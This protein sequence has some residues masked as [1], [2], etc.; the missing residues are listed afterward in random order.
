MKYFIGVDG[1]ATQSSAAVAGTNGKIISRKSGPALNYHAIGEKQCEKN[2]RKLLQ[3]LLKKYK[4]VKT[5]VIGFAGLDSPQDRQAYKKIVKKVLPRNIKALLFNDAE[6]ALEAACFDHKKPRILIICGTGSSVYGEYGNK[7][8]KAIGWGFLLGDDG[9][10]FWLGS[11]ALRSAVRVWDGREKK[12]VLE[13]LVL[14]KAGKKDISQLI[15]EIYDYWHEKP[16]EFKK[17][18]ASF[19][20]LFH[21]AKKDSV[22][23]KIIEQAAE[24]L[25]LGARAVAKK[26]GIRNKPFCVG[27]IGS[28]FKNP[29]LLPAL[30]GKIK[31]Q[32]P[33]VHFVYNVNPL[34]G[35]VNL[36]IK[37]AKS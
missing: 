27:F 36:A 35:A 15:P 1:G 16:E 37:H 31:K 30:V 7:K 3:P 12:T 20:T 33:K 18:I 14:R 29:G 5:I 13:K 8:A 25:A 11:W 22:A 28:G 26:L 23:K 6:I 2:L 19:A 21:E 4:V 34:Q 9:S 17:Y 24:E 32:H 10:A